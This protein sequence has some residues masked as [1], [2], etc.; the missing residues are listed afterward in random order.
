MSTNSM[1][2]MGS[3]VSNEGKRLTRLVVARLKGEAGYGDRR[4]VLSSQSLELGV[5]VGQ[6]PPL[7]TVDD[8]HHLRRRCVASAAYS[9]V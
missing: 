8:A 1:L 6:V 5:G 9:R 7:R 3:R 2:G 4:R